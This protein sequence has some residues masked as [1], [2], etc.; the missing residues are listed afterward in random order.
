MPLDS[1]RKQGRSKDGLQYECK[2]CT[3]M[4]AAERY[5]SKKDE[6]IQKNIAWQNDNKEKHAEAALRYYNSPTGRLGRALNKRLDELLGETRLPF[7]NLIGL[8]PSTL[9][10]HLATYLSKET[11][12]TDYGTK[13]KVKTATKFNLDDI[14]K[15]P[16]IFFWPNL[17]PFLIKNLDDTDLPV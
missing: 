14:K 15:D 12:I 17:I 2:L 5:K 11:S 3:T 8:S 10:L 13:W 16:S 7:I 4:R 9:I 6:I 1:F